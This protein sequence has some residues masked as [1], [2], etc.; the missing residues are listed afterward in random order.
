MSYFLSSQQAVRASELARVTDDLAE[1]AEF[2]EDAH[3]DE[4]EHEEAEFA[5]DAHDDE[6]E[7]RPQAYSGARWRGIIA[8]VTIVPLLLAVVALTWSTALSPASPSPPLPPAPPPAPPVPPHLLLDTLAPAKLLARPLPGLSPTGV[9]HGSSSAASPP[10]SYGDGTQS[11]S[12]RLGSAQG[13]SWR[14]AIATARVLVANMTRAEKMSYVRGEGWVGYHLNDGF[15]VGAVR[16]VARLGIPSINIQDGPAGYRT[17]DNRIVGS[18]TEWPSQ[19]ALGATWDPALAYSYAEALGREFQAHGANV[20]L[21][22]GI[23]I[24]RV[25]HCGRTAE[26]M[27]G[28]EPGLGVVLGGEYVRG[29][30]SV[31]VAAVAKHFVANTQENFRILVDARISRRALHEVYYPPWRAA[32][33]AGIASIMCGYNMVNGVHACGPSDVLRDL[34]GPLGFR[35]WCVSMSRSADLRVVSSQ[36]CCRPT[37]PCLL[38]QRSARNRAPQG[39]E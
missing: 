4:N 17:T 32:V 39:D 3:D 6:N 9:C 35:G 16:A 14:N 34:K 2:A 24:A 20:A 37:L 27:T 5:E 15:Y 28:E 11:V 36:P 21:G 29:L 19:L 23:N 8:V 25:A 7:H 31:G 10:P 30:Q 12:R 26:Y 1:E 33:R 13:H 38:T 22:P 18:V